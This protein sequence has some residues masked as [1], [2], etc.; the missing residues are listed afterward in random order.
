MIAVKASQR[1]ACK[2]QPSCDE[3]CKASKD[4]QCRSNLDVIQAL[5][6]ETL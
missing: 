1:K 5:P 6:V 3:T 4:S 2:P